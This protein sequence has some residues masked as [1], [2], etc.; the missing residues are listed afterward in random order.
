M[1]NVFFSI[2]IDLIGQLAGLKSSVREK[3]KEAG[4]KFGFDHNFYL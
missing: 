4:T 1:E 3:C 2:N